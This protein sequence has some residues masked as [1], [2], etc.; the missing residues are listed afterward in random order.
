MPSGLECIKFE[1]Y[2]VFV[3]KDQP[4]PNHGVTIMS[5][6]DMFKHEPKHATMDHR[7]ASAK[8]GLE[9]AMRIHGINSDRARE[10]DKLID[11][12]EAEKRYA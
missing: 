12:L 9:R 1:N 5:F 4:I 10:F 8:R 6:F 3:N 7:L 11:K 2:I